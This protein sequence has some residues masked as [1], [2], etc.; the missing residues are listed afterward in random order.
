MLIAIGAVL[1]LLGAASLFIPIPHRQRHGI[2]VG[3]VSLGVETTTREKVHPGISAV[4][5]AG[6]V[7]LML[8]GRRSSRA[9]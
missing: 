8:A 7:I 2:D 4:L 3:S 9:A 5:I 1:L 6:G